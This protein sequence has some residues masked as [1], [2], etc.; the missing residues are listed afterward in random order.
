MLAA[1]CH[2]RLVARQAGY[3]PMAA[4]IAAPIVRHREETH[5]S[6]GKEVFSEHA[7]VVVTDL[8]SRGPLVEASVWPGAIHAVATK[9]T[10]V[11]SVVRRRLV[12]TYKRIGIE[13]VTQEIRRHVA[14]HQGFGP[15][16]GGAGPIRPKPPTGRC[17]R[18]VGILRT[19]Q[20][21]RG[22]ALLRRAPSQRKDSPPG[23]TPTGQPPGGA[24]AHLPRTG[25]ALRRADCLAERVSPCRLT[26]YGR[27]MSS[28]A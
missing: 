13:P 16:P 8:G 25:C 15:Q 19:D 14:H 28:L 24:S 23:T 27:G 26:P 4:R 18:S 9:H 12:E 10:R 17:V 22:T 20:I 5:A 6:R 7:V 11:D 2:G 1:H 21:P 3:E